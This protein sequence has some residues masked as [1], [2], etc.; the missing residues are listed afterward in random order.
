VGQTGRMRLTGVHHVSLM[1]PDVDTALAFY[2]DVLGLKTRADR[3]NFGVAGAWLDVG[4][5]QVHLIEGPTP[6]SAGQHFAVQVEDLDDVVA[7]LRGHGLPVADPVSTGVGRQ[8]IVK[9]PAGNVIE[10]N[11]PN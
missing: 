4:G 1:T 9:D 11:Q 3:P 10:L 7:E 2:I 5:Q 8:T 6:T